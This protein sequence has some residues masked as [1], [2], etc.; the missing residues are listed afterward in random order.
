MERKFKIG[1]HVYSRLGRR[2]ITGY[3]NFI[4]NRT[5]DGKNKFT[6]S[7]PYLVELKESGKRWKWLAESDLEPIKAVRLKSK[8]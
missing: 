7:T 8:Q 1:D 3:I 5:F 2:L 6:S 4:D